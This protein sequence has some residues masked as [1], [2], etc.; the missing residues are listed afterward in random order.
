[1]DIGRSLI[2]WILG[3]ADWLCMYMGTGRLG[4]AAVLKRFKQKSQEEVQTFVALGPLKAVT[5]ENKRAPRALIVLISSYIWS[6]LPCPK[7]L[8]LGLTKTIFGFP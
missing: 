2:G 7:R 8:V 3:S 6:I 4:N 1:M 5:S